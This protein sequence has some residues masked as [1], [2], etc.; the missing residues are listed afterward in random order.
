[1]NKRTRI[2]ATDC[3]RGNDCYKIG[4]LFSH[5][6]GWVRK[7]IPCRDGIGCA[8]SNCSCVHPDNWEWRKNIDCK[9]LGKCANHDC[10]YKHPEGWAWRSNVDCKFANNCMAFKAGMCK[11][12]H[13]VINSENNADAVLVNMMGALT[14]SI[15]CKFGME[16]FTKGCFYKHPEGHDHRKNTICKFGVKCKNKDTTCEF[17]HVKIEKPSASGGGMAVEG[18][19]VKVPSQSHKKP[20]EKP[21][22][23][24]VSAPGDG[25][26]GGATAESMTVDVNI[27]EKIKLAIHRKNKTTNDDQMV[28]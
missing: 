9:L 24:N 2:D 1:M 5:P 7:L 18:I 23:E 16:C 11:F 6:A 26:G 4:C 3:H 14:V 8:K 27:G 15:D 17:K 25:G 28:V 10:T 12:K 20:V 19:K 21:K 13:V 22:K